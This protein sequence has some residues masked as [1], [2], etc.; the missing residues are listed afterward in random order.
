MSIRTAAPSLAAA[1]LLAVA[2]GCGILDGDPENRAP[3]ID[4]LTAAPAAD[5][6]PGDT[7]TVTVAAHDPEGRELGYA[8]T[9]T[10]GVFPGDVTSASTPWIA[11]AAAGSCTLTVRVDDGRDA[12]ARDL[13]VT[14]S[15]R[16]PPALAAAAPR[17][18]YGIAGDRLPVLLWNSGDGEVAWTATTGGVVDFLVP[19][20]TSGVLTTDVDTLWV[21]ADRSVLAIGDHTG[22]LDLD[23]GGAG[24]RR[25][26]LR[27]TQVAEQA[28]T[29]QVVASH[30]HD[31]ECFTEGLFWDDGTLVESGGLYG[32]SDLRRVDLETGEVLQRVPLAASDFGEGT[33]G[34][35]DRVLQ[36]TWQQHRAYVRDRATF[37][38]LDTFNYTTEGWGLTQDGARLI[39]SDGTPTLYFRDPDTFA[40][41]GRV[42]VTTGGA[43]LYRINELEWIDGLV[44]AN[45]WLTDYLVRIDPVT[46]DVVDWLDLT[47]LLT[48]A[49]DA[50]A[51]EMNGIAYDAATGRIFVTGKDWPLLFEITA[52]APVV[53][54]R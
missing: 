5:A 21:T 7:L 49:Q 47:G 4:S 54:V 2:V 44:W 17:S 20:A 37:A 42:S 26:L 46:G 10:A 27:A 33:T 28:F 13:P 8:W 1:C 35:R 51:D 52:P 25:I 24:A 45:V 16:T 22:I 11:P 3:V 41:T 18:R 12:V 34:W 38:P 14:V 53:P 19:D 36:L 30:P 6:H 15:P 43:P 23:G 32:S 48:P 39:M 9:A 31:P 40:E 50:A 29:V